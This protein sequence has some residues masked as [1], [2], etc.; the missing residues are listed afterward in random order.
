[1][2]TPRRKAGR[3]ARPS[4]ARGRPPLAK[5]G[6]T[7]ISSKASRAV[8]RSHH[9]LRK[10]HAQALA[11]SDEQEAERIRRALAETGGLESYQAA[12][13]LGQSS[14]RGGDTSK[15]LVEWLSPSI[16]AVEKRKATLQ[17]LEVGSLSSQN[18]CS[19]VP[20][21]RVR[22]IDLKAR[23][24]GIEEIDFMA[25]P[26]PQHEEALFDIVSLSLVL[27]F[28][29]D[30]ES[31]GQML[32]RLPSFLHPNRDS[33]FPCLFLVLP[34][35]CVTNSRYLTEPHLEQILNRLNFVSLHVKRTSKLHYSLWRWTGERPGRQQSSFGK[36]QLHPGRNRNNFAIVLR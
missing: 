26:I 11:A 20:C 3:D 29:P 27:N 35:P 19:K 21:I 15:V 36:Q 34:L 6:G 30:P 1:M 31:R 10:L 13:A 16:Q 17:M 5:L 18:A 4:L 9:S 22:R 12:S 14:D 32:A 24:P 7:S 28:V 25:M 33:P 2:T 8:I 23:E